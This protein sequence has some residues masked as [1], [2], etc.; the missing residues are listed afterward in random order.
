M[1]NFARNGD[2]Y[3]IDGVVVTKAEWEARLAMQI[4]DEREQEEAVDDGDELPPD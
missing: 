4:E 2:D 3:T 1:A